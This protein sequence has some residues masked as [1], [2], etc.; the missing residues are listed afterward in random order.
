MA[1]SDWQN[2][3]KNRVAQAIVNCAGIVKMKSNIVLSK[4]KF[5]FFLQFGKTK[6][7]FDLTSTGSRYVWRRIFLGWKGGT[8][9][10]FTLTF[11][12]K[13]DIETFKLSV[14]FSISPI[15]WNHCLLNSN[16]RIWVITSS[17]A[18]TTHCFQL[19]FPLVA[20]FRYARCRVRDALSRSCGAHR[21]RH[22]P[23]SWSNHRTSDDLSYY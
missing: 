3:I 10:R 9:K 20:G 19:S 13:V 14:L 21:F 17:S 11:Q 16:L 7:A 5:W 1:T 18:P 2:E 8:L 6:I 4:T 23:A 22:D 12:I 15:S